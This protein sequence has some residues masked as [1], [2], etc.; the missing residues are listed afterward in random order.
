M[1]GFIY[2]VTRKSDGAVYI[3]KQSRFQTKNPDLLP[4]DIMG[5]KYFTSS[6]AIKD[7]WKQHPDAYDWDILAEE[8][9]DEYV[10]AATEALYI[11]KAWEEEKSG[12]GPYMLNRYCNLRFHRSGS[13][14]HIDR[15]D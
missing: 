11:A 14:K 13:Y 6:K 8:I 2:R 9:T 3:G 5:I 7:D 15:G 10:L 1:K 12:K 4:D